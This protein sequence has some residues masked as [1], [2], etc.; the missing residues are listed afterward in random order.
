MVWMNFK[1]FNQ[2]GGFWV[3]SSQLIAMV[4]FRPLRGV[5]EPLPNDL[6]GL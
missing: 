1:G 6:N 2:I 4:S 5:V 3:G